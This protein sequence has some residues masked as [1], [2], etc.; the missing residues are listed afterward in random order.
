MRHADRR[1]ASSSAGG[2]AALG[3]RLDRLGFRVVPADDIEDVLRRVRET[4]GRIAVL[5]ADDGGGIEPS[6]LASRLVAEGAPRPVDILTLGDGQ[7]PKADVTLAD[8]PATVDDRRLAACV[9]VALARSGPAVSISATEA[10]LA[11]RARHRSRI[12]LAEDIRTNQQVIGAIL[13]RAGH[14]VAI[15]ASG[16]EVL[17]RLETERFDIVLTDINMPGMSGFEL[18]KM[19]RF[20]HPPA[21][22]PPIV[23][24]SADATGEARATAHELGFSAYLTKP[25]DAV[26]LVEA[27][28]VLVAPMADPV[29]RE[30]QDAPEPPEPRPTRPDG[31]DPA[32]L[33]RSKLDAL[34]RL[35]GDGAFVDELIGDFV[36]DAEELI[37]RLR[38]AVA[39]GDPRAVRDL[40]HAL[41]SSAAHLGAQALL[42]LTLGWRGLDDAALV[43]RGR[44]ELAA[45]DGA[46]L[47]LR[48]ALTAYRAERAGIPTPA[49]SP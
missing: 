43:M 6:A 9:E 36:A 14:E 23:A 49:S 5:L 8:L 22:L 39:A 1:A 25:V 32:V 28:D 10:I 33:D 42:E 2:G 27:I 21:S 45:L 34:R 19:L 17:E 26:E 11:L 3:A 30:R 29:A 20:A 46:F 13:R 31:R 41:R 24:L 38:E 7:Y 18:V 12:L 15:V 4:A 44:R 47:D 40:A 37:G 16:E 48:S 35:D